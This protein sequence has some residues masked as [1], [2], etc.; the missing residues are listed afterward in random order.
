MSALSALYKVKYS[1]W[2]DLLS[3]IE[4]RTHGVLLRFENGAAA[5]YLPQVWDDLP[6]PEEFLSS[7]CR[8]AGEEADAWKRGGMQAY[9]YTVQKM[10]ER[11]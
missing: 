2:K 10:A 11:G 6:G 7:L 9:V 5:T 8:K 3:K 4:P 1:D